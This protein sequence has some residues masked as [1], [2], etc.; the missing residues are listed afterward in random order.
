MITVVARRKLVATLTFV[1]AALLVACAG[2]STPS[3]SPA[4]STTASTA[5]ATPT[6]AGSATTTPTAVGSA[7]PIDTPTS[8]VP[9]ATGTVTPAGFPLTVEGTDGQSVTFDSP[10]QRIVSLSAHATDI[11]CAVGAGPQIVAV[12]K[13]ANCPAG[14]SAK[15]ELDAFSP[16]TEAIAGYQPDFVY[17]STDTGNLAAT[18]RGLG[19]RVL[20]LDIPTS[21]QGVFDQVDLFGRISGH[22]DAAAALVAGMQTRLEAVEAKVA[23]V[24]RGPRVFHELDTTLFTVAPGTYIGDL[25]RVLKAQNIAA[26]AKD[27]YPQL[28][29]E[30]VVQRDPEVIVLADEV[31]GVTPESVAARPG[32]S[33]ITAVKTGRICGVDP[34]LVSQPGTHV[35]D[36]LETL[37]RC[38]YPD[39]FGG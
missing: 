37:A 22:Q 10:P 20:Y 33:G 9:F 32:W 34:S 5:T 16:N 19:L 28:T 36:A 12:D 39:R 24:T 29:A 14:S 17:I 30:I 1:A 23:G 8:P 31:A 21:L 18:L 27:S 35:L 4:T 6:A 11:L 2:D 3:A 7:V 13:Y 38:L 26:D 25:Y 15:P